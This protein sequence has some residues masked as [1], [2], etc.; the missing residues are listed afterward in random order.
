MDNIGSYRHSS[1]RVSA[2][3]DRLL[4]TVMARAAADFEFVR[5]TGVL[6]SL[7]TKASRIVKE[8]FTQ[9]S[10]KSPTFLDQTPVLAPA[11]RARAHCRS[12]GSDRGVYPRW[13]TTQ[14]HEWRKS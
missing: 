9:T 12:H 6:Q 1:G 4:R 10:C 3:G 2:H 7:T 11:A 14:Q 8:Q 13:M 5:T